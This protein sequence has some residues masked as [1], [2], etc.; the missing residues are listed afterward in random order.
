[1]TKHSRLIA[2]ILTLLF[3]LS[4]CTA[5]TVYAEPDGGSDS[6]G[7]SSG[8]GQQGGNDGGSDSGNDGG[9]DSGN[10]HQQGDD[11]YND[12]GNSGG[13]SYDDDDDDDSGYNNQNQNNRNSYSDYDEEYDYEGERSSTGEILYVGGDQTYV[14]PAT[15]PSTTAALYDTSKVKVDESTLTKSDWADIKQKLTASANTDNNPDTGDF[16]FIQKNTSVEDNGHWMLYLGFALIGLGV[17]GIIFLIIKASERRKQMAAA[18]VRTVN[19][20][21]PAPPAVP[22]QSAPAKKSGKRNLRYR[23][24]SEYGD[25]Y[26]DKPKGGTR[27]SK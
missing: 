7:I 18:T 12:G 20:E 11:S 2:A 9:S 22:Q 23:D 1:M 24:D 8:D 16:A 19:T 10:D 21:R 3:V 14:P 25:D 26:G 5:L 13:N 17:I 6:P 27:F 15:I 4:A